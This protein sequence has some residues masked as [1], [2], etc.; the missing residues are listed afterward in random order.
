MLSRR[1]K[2]RRINIASKRGTSRLRVEQLED[3][4]LLAVFTVVNTNDAGPGSL[5]QAIS[6]ANLAPGADSVVFNIPGPNPH[7]IH[8]LSA[9]P[10][11]SGP[12][13]IDGTTQPGYQGPAPVVGIDGS[14]VPGGVVNGLEITAGNSTVRGLLIGLFSGV[15]LVL[16][17]GGGN[18]VAGNYIGTNFIGTLARG[19]ARGGILV[20]CNNNLIGGGTLAARNLVSGNGGIGI[21]ISS[22][23]GN[24]V[25]GNFVGT[26]AGGG[27]AL[28]NNNY[29]VVLDRGAQDNLIGTDGNGVDD[30]GERNLISGNDFAGVGMGGLNTRNN[31]V[32]GNYIGTNRDGMAAVPNGWAGVLL[33][34]R[35]QAN[36]IGTNGDGVADDAERNV[37]SGNR[38]DGVRITDATT[39]FNVVA[40]N[41][42]GTTANGLGRIANGEDAVEVV[43]GARGNRIGTDGNG[44]ADTAERNVLSGN[45]YSGIAVK[46]GT[47]ATI[48]AGNF[49]GTTASGTGRLGNDRAGIYMDGG[50]HSNV[51]GTNGDGV[52]D[53]A[54]RN[55][56]AANGW[57]GV[58]MHPGVR[59]N[60]IAGNYIG[61]DAT[62][63]QRMGNSWNNVGIY[64]NTEQNRVGTNGDG[65]SDEAERNVIAD[66]GYSGVALHG[67]RN[68]TI[69]GN[70][71]GTNAQGTLSLGNRARGV[72]LCCGAQ[73]NVI[74]TNGDGL[75]DEA[76]RNVI[77]GNSD[78][79]IYM[80]HGN[81]QFNTVA[82]N[83][84][85][86]TADGLSGLRN[87]P[88]G[89]FIDGASQNRL[90][91]DGNGIADGAERNIIGLHLSSGVLITGTSATGNTV[92]GNYVGTDV[93]GMLALGIPSHVYGVL[94]TNGA[95]NN[96]IGGTLP[97][98]RNLISG[99]IFGVALAD[100]TTA[101][102]QVRGNAIGTQADGASRLGNLA[103]GVMIY[104]GAR[105]NTI[106]GTVPGAGN[107]IAYSGGSGVVV[108][109]GTGNAIRRNAVF[110]NVGLGIDLGFDGVT[111][112][113]IPYLYWAWSVG[114]YVYTGGAVYGESLRQFEVEFFASSEADPSGY[115]EGRT[116]VGEVSVVT[117]DQGLGYFQPAFQVAVPPGHC[118]SGTATDM[119]TGTTAEFGNCVT[120]EAATGPGGGSTAGLPWAELLEPQTLGGGM[121][122]Q[123]LPLSAARSSQTGTDPRP[124]VA[125]QEV[126][127]SPTVPAARE[128][129]VPF[130]PDALL[131]VL[132]WNWLD[133]W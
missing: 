6:D 80:G 17:G 79:G 53:L 89:V 111:W 10:V 67:A 21:R 28:A 107:V 104:N 26:Q 25:Q 59:Q 117:D 39:D 52:A 96:L 9:L 15:G 98:A 82:G 19:N 60:I 118:L 12:V 83:Y 121:Q 120:V 99:N 115:G 63:T 133:S 129:Q 55:V 100:T 5:R 32:A 116:Y 57:E 36:R 16:R 77:S 54:E 40:G 37:I 95:S 84:I 123:A 29:G 23:F 131:D 106:G 8:V 43:N 90:G 33:N 24:R 113:N 88:N 7:S 86:T 108:A 126:E 72:Y 78:D 1:S 73:F 11:V 58:A 31:A 97:A 69:A 127:M 30:V 34:D 68:T 114:G 125:P 47:S 75:A 13:V 105:S 18:V 22:V 62:G 76:E 3:R 65:V 70:Y 44:M 66:S 124:A 74:G 85:G 93:T 35:V 64:E 45:G 94:L 132:A 14:S 101:D 27:Q 91:T 46:A 92:A 128:R 103:H 20:E 71:I 81:T 41:Y 42:I 49:I 51:I 48:I 122:A 2:S 130:G 4:R 110:A 112:W 50:T 102:N 61:T 38:E 119:T 109:S 56:I 87:G